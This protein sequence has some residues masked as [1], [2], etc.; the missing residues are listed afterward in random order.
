[1]TLSLP[2]WQKRTL[3]ILAAIAVVALFALAFTAGRVSAGPAT[4]ATGF[5]E[6]LEIAVPLDV[7]HFAAVQRR[8]NRAVNAGVRFE[9]VDHAGTDREGDHDKQKIPTVISGKSQQRPAQSE[10]RKS[11]DPSSDGVRSGHV[12]HTAAKS[13]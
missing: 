2:G 13:G 5:V 12:Q 4:S 11:P 7:G 10:G 1:M 9:E 3:A 6:Q 8:L